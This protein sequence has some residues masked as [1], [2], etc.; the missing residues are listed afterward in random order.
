MTLSDL[1]KLTLWGDKYLDHVKRTMS[2]KTFVEKQTVLQNFYTF[3]GNESIKSLEQITT[4]KAYTFLSKINDEKGSNVANKY[5]KN[6]LAAWTWGINFVD[7]FPKLFS[8]FLAIRPFHVKRQDRYV[9]P[10]E[11]LIKVLQHATGQDLIFLLTLYFT[12]ARRGEIFKL[13]WQDINFAETKIRLTDNKAGGKERVRWL[14][15]HP[16]LVKALKWWKEN[17][18]CPVENVFMQT[19]C[20]SK[21]G[22]PFTQRM[23]FMENLCKKAGVKEFGF[24]AIRHTSAAI[25]FVQS[26]LNAAQILMGHYRTSTTDRY[27][28]SAGLYSDQNDIVEALGDSDVGQIAGNLLTLNISAE[29]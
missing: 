26:G 24:H 5:R 28:K 7:D 4:A 16:E 20:N 9:P 17:R 8:P 19:H 13:T 29:N 3:C 14:Q 12:G 15:M 27:I 23:H 6:L 2:H 21:M 1:E 22:L 10:V 11:D 18:P 25:T